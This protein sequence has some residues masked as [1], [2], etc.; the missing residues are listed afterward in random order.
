[1]FGGGFGDNDE[2]DK[3]IKALINL[4]I[5]LNSTKNTSRLC[6]NLN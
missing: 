5:S 3:I 6:Q 4:V 1:M 2:C